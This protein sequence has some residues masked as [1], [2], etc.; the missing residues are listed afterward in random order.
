MNIRQKDWNSQELVR[1]KISQGY[2]GVFELC[3]LIQK[4]YL[5]FSFMLWTTGKPTNNESRS[6]LANTSKKNQDIPD[7]VG[8]NTENLSS[9]VKSTWSIKSKLTKSN[10]FGTDLFTLRA[11][12]TFINLW[13][14][15][16]KAL[17]LMHFDIEYHIC[18]KTNA[19]SYT[20]DGVISWMTLDQTFSNHVTHKNLEANFSKSEIGQWYPIAFFSKKMIV[21]KTWYKTYNQ[22]PW[23]II[24]VFKT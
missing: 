24:K 13:K 3:K 22:K 6:T 8:K 16:I 15:F 23:A 4:F 11:K 7:G 10:S 17:I 5:K 12:K 9:V 2:L 20:I 18:I 21:V 19:L 14:V 1:T